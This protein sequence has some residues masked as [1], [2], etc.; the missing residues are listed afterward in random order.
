M[1]TNLLEGDGVQ[2][3]LPLGGGSGGGGVCRLCSPRAVSAPK[4]E[5]Q[6]AREPGDALLGALVDGV[7]QCFLAQVRLVR[8]ALLLFLRLLSLLGRLL[9]VRSVKYRAVTSESILPL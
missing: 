5:P 6:Q 4:A 7:Y 2:A 8:S 9:L 3:A 1:G